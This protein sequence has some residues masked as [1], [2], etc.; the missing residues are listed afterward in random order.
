MM[1]ICEEHLD[2]SSYL[3]TQ[4]ERA[5][6]AP[7]YDLS[8][9]A[10]LEERLLAHLDGLVEGGN[11][12]A[13]TLLRPALEAE[14]E[15]RVASAA[16]ALVANAG[17]E[18]CQAL[19]RDA[20]PERRTSIQRALELCM[21]RE[22]GASLLPL[23]KADDP[24]L[25]ATA[26][27][28]LMVRQEVPDTMLADLLAHENAR[29]RTAAL[30]GLRALPRNSPRNM[31]SQALA[32]PVSALR[33][34]A[35]EAGLV[36]GVRDAWTVCRMAIEAHDEHGREPMVLWAMGCE[37]KDVELLVDLL[38]E[39]RL[40]ANALWALGFSGWA[41]A[42]DACLAWLADDAVAR[43]AGEAF[44]AI[45]GLRLEDSYVLPEQEP[46]EEPI[47]LE[48]EDLDA[49]LVPRPEDA[50]PRPNPE[51]ITEW[52]RGARGRFERRTRYLMGHP[53]QGEVLL[54]ALE[55][56]S[57]RRRHV[58]A[59]ELAIRSRGTC[60]IST[61]LLTRQQRAGLDRAQGVSMRISAFPFARLLS[62]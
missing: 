28:V 2:E 53:F 51:A 12:V 43:L 16:F 44:S 24:A 57:M 23:L 41:A 20:S 4:W 7:D 42:A 31:L 52:W 58:H 47:P 1:D 26:L 50:L 27:E 25:V 17:K 54:A 34:A 56:G 35:I 19:L 30:K 37:E 60:H 62:V 33:D 29:V 45:T 6:V 49:D 48:Q 11:P 14:E 46:P 13:E 21:G 5:L 15:T 10:E 9:T 39:P 3:W 32:S 61:R 36:A 40:R 22:L 18:E 55:R 8:D 59:R 38:Q